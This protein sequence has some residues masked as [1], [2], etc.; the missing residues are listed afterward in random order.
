MKPIILQT[1]PPADPAIT[2]AALQSCSGK[3]EEAKPFI[4]ADDDIPDRIADFRQSAKI[5]ML[6]HQF[7]ESRFF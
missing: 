4:V 2:S 6:L 1:M 3:T 5:M 7:L